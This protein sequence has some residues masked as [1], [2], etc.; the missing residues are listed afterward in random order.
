MLRPS[1]NPKTSKRLGSQCLAINECTDWRLWI[2][3]QCQ[4]QVGKKC[5]VDLFQNATQFFSTRTCMIP[6][7]YQSQDI[8]I[9]QHTL[10]FHNPTKAT[11]TSI[12]FLKADDGIPWRTRRLSLSHAW[13]NCLQVHR[14]V[15]I[16]LDYSN[17]IALSFSFLSVDSKVKLTQRQKPLK[18]TWTKYTLSARFSSYKPTD[19]CRQ[20][21]SNYQRKSC[22]MWLNFLASVLTYLIPFMLWTRLY[23]DHKEQILECLSSRCCTT[24]L[25]MLS[26]DYDLSFWVEILVIWLREFCAPDIVIWFFCK[27]TW[28]SSSWTT[29]TDTR[30]ELHVYIFSNPPTF[31]GSHFTTY[32]SCHQ[33]LKP[34]HLELG[35]H[36]G[37]TRIYPVRWVFPR[38]H[39]HPKTKP[40]S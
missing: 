19:R 34:A 25:I 3:G 33:V 6:V 13:R 5:I 4:V 2:E 12:N 27:G 21:N 18:E 32:Q 23:G 1:T 9:S 14:H 8:T 20:R 38:P 35:Q 40:S 7:K 39:L 26:D 10:C 28:I 31:S 15:Y 17:I 16:M 30:Y 22:H 11:T 29:C 24:V 36:E 37:F